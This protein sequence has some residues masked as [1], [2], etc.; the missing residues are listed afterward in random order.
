MFKEIY[1]VKVPGENIIPLS[2]AILLKSE[3][4][5]GQNFRNHLL[6]VWFYR[7][8]LLHYHKIWTPTLL[9]SIFSTGIE[10]PCIDSSPKSL[11]KY[12]FYAKMF[13]RS[14]ENCIENVLEVLVTLLSDEYPTVAAT[15]KASILNFSIRIHLLCSSNSQHLV[16][17]ILHGY[18]AR[19]HE[20]SSNLVFVAI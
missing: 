13:Y 11:F 9:K 20:Y 8:Q 16:F 19:H 4:G 3:Q 10:P 15:S 6:V 2:K 5:V 14:L 1:S 18:K 7:T 17:Q 12:S